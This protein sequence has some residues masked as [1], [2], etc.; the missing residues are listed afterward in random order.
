VQKVY[1]RTTSAAGVPAVVALLSDPRPLTAGKSAWCL[2]TA[3]TEFCPLLKD[4]G[5]ASISVSH[6]GFD[7]A[8][9]S[10]LSRKLLQRH[11]LYHETRRAVD[12]TGIAYMSEL[13]DWPTATACCNHDVQNAL[14]WSLQKYVD[15]PDG[16][17]TSTSL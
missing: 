6:Y 15:G 13:L 11:V 4:L 8:M 16:T 9:Y 17:A 3:A 1:V 5:H 10:A 12:A 2:Y 7:R 14:K